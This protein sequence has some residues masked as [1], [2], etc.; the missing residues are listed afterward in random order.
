VRIEERLVVFPEVVGWHI[1]IVAKT[2]QESRDAGMGEVAKAT[3]DTNGHYSLS[4]P[5]SGPYLVR[6]THQG[7]GYFIAAPEGGAGSWPRPRRRELELG[8]YGRSHEMVGQVSSGEIPAAVSSPSG[9]ASG[10][11]SFGLPAAMFRRR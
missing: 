7:A 10:A 6:V 2:E 1:A 4:E 3:T 9:I 11:G 8:G 5:G